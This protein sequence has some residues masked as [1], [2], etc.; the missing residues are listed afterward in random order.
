MP[1][2]DDDRKKDQSDK[3]PPLLGEKTWSKFCEEVEVWEMYTDVPEAKR[4]PKISAKSFKEG[5]ELNQYGLNWCKAN[6]LLAKQAA[7]DA[8]PAAPGEA[9]EPGS[10]AITEVKSGVAL[11][12]DHLR[13]KAIA[14]ED[15]V[16]FAQF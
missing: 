14:S 3:I 2:D 6:K 9:G 16:T 7:R 4:A 8:V 15:L 12:L 13:P 1:G 10:P 5:S 11:L